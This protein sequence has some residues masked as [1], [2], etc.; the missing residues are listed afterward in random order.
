VTRGR[1]IAAVVA[2]LVIGA[3]VAGVAVSAR[4]AVPEV[5]V[6]KAEKQTLGVIVTASG[7]IEAADK[8]DVYPPTAGTLSDVEVVDG[9]KVKEGDVLAQMDTGPIEIQVQQALAGV[10]AAQAQYA[11]ASA[12][13]PTPQQ[14]S[15]ANA[16]I[17]AANAGYRAAKSAYDSFKDVYDHSP[18]SVQASMEATLTQLNI[19]KKNAYSGLKQAQA[20]KSQLVKAQNVSAAHEAALA[21]EDQANEAYRVAKNTLDKATMVAPMDGVVIFNALGAPGADGTTPKPSRGAAVAPQ[22][23]TFSVVQLGEVGFTAQVDEADVARVKPGMKAVVTLDAFPGDSF[24]AKVTSVKTAAIQTTTGGIAFPVKM[25]IVLNGKI[26]LLGM[27][28]SSD[29]EVDAVRDAIVVPIEAIF[30][31][32]NKKYVYIVKVD[33]VKKTEVKT[34]ALTDTQA[35]VLEGVQVGDIVATGNLSTLKDG[36]TVRVK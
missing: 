27:S 3:V 35:Q 11:A 2:L 20:G 21:A 22:A 1:I 25:S 7:D 10:Q 29:I 23:A 5:T 4:N 31:E 28:G 18:P 6:A 16:A 30:D 24:E 9:Q 34:G 19:A 32:N 17:D 13:V 26:L 12:Q 33:K 14:M 36:M 8:A 15:A